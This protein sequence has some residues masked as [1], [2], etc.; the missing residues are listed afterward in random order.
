MRRL[1]AGV[2]VIYGFSSLAPLGRHAGPMLEGFLH[3]EGGADFGSGRVNNRLVSLFAPSSMVVTSGQAAGEPWA[4]ERRATCRLYDERKGLGARV[5]AWH[6]VLAGPADGVRMDFDRAEAFFGDLGEAAGLDPAAAVAF[7][8]IGDDAP[9]RDAFMRLMRATGD[10]ALRLRMI[11]LGARVGWLTAPQVAQ[12]KAGLARDV[13]ADRAMDYGEVELV[14][15]LDGTLPVD[16]KALARGLPAMTAPQAA[17]L[18]CLGDPE[19]HRRVLRAVASDD[20]RDV[21]AAQAY[22]R[23]RSLGEPDALRA[24]VASV[25]SMKAGPAQVRAL[26]TLARHHLDDP[27]AL[28]ALVELF[29]RT[30]SLAVQRAIAEVFLRSGRESLDATTVA[31]LRRHRLHEGATPDIIDSVIGRLAG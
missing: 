29:S 25:A 31:A 18:A 1:F 28:S 3:G 7:A 9:A 4:D 30:R 11:A 5:A 26:E 12:E 22:L 15:G 16:R 24:V 10:P 13:I 21:R 19:A 8:A 23:H 27:G 14:C 17:A 6:A 20:E 2:P